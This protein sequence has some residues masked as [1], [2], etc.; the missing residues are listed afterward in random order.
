M[1]VLIILQD[2]GLLFEQIIEKF[3]EKKRST[4]VLLLVIMQFVLE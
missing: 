4:L 1:H 3:G 2:A